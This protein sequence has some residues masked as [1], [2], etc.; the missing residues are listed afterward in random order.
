MAVRGSTSG[1]LPTSKNVY[2]KKKETRVRYKVRVHQNSYWRSVWPLDGDFR[3][4]ALCCF[5]SPGGDLLGTRLPDTFSKIHVG[6]TVYLFNIL[7]SG[8]SSHS[9]LKDII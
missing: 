7:S 9:Y 1:K 3:D 2:M 4:V 6:T 5:C 8:S